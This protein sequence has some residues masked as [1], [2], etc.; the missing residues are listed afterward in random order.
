MALE[1][2]ILPARYLSVVDLPPFLCR[3]NHLQTLSL[4]ETFDSPDIFAKWKSADKSKSHKKIKSIFYTGEWAVTPSTDPL[5]GAR[6]DQSLKVLTDKHLHAI[7]RVLDKPVPLDGTNDVVIQYEV[8]FPESLVCGGGY[9]RLLSFDKDNDVTAENIHEKFDNDM[10]Q[11]IIFGPD[12]CRTNFRCHYFISRAH[13]KSE[14]KII[15][16]YGDGVM[17][18]GGTSVFNMYTLVVKS[19]G[20]FKVKI[21]GKEVVHEDYKNFVP[22]VYPP[23]QIPDPSA[24]NPNKDYKYYVIDEK[25]QKPADWDEL[26]PQYI[27]DAKQKIPEGWREDISLYVPASEEMQSEYKSLWDDSI[28]GE[29]VPPLVLNPLCKD[30]MCGKWTPS[31]IP[32]PD[33]RGEWSPPIIPNPVPPV[34]W[35]PPMIDNPDYVEVT[36]PHI[37][38]TINAIAFDI[39]STDGGIEFDNIYVGSSEAEADKIAKETLNRRAKVH[40]KGSSLSEKVKSAIAM[41]DGLIASSV[42]GLK[43]LV[44]QFVTNPSSIVDY[45]QNLRAN[46]PLVSIISTAL[47]S[48][49]LIGYAFFHVTK[50]VLCLCKCSSKTQKPPGDKSSAQSKD[51]S[52]TDA[53]TEDWSAGFEDTDS[54]SNKDTK[55]DLKRRGNSSKS[56]KNKSSK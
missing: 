46:V 18:D 14:D 17:I 37:L 45:L 2:W 53:K 3:F 33:Y 54:P 49:F 43:S 39:W 7:V 1:P 51:D 34:E 5:D 56:S 30:K 16:G 48:F 11:I 8:K 10:S 26:Q 20:T 25:A 12:R 31:L 27:P 44:H 24:D 41:A 4:H 13:P 15:H 36:D 35:N 23:K 50:K 9:V 22:P 29:Y 6:K 28:L 21:N 19:D 32:N 47:A 55:G 38:G 40:F 42:H 52:D